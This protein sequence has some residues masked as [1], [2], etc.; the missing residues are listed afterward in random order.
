MNCY[1]LRSTECSS[2]HSIVYIFYTPH[3]MIRFTAHIYVTCSH[4]TIMLMTLLYDPCSYK[5]IDCDVILN[6]EYYVIV[7]YIMLSAMYKCCYIRQLGNIHRKE[8]ITMMMVAPY[9]SAITDNFR[10][11]KRFFNRLPCR[12]ITTISL[13][14]SLLILAQM[15]K[16]KLKKMNKM[17]LTS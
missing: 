1:Q 6:N 10:F 9:L 3:Y 7:I 14:N 16:K 2:P 5:H 13:K 8:R 11:L 17:F 15:Y 12:I 4:L